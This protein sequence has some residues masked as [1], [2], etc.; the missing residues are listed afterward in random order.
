MVRLSRIDGFQLHTQDGE[1]EEALT[2]AHQRFAWIGVGTGHSA[3]NA[4]LVCKYAVINP[5]NIW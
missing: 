2:S 5:D 3:G 4:L 1:M